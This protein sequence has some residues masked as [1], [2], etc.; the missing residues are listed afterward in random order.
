MAECFAC[1]GSGEF[2]HKSGN[3]SE[4]RKCGG[5]G[6]YEYPNRPRKEKSLLGMMVGTAIAGY[7]KHKIG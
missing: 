5:S 4:C 6:R 1:K 3:T 7:I 2:T